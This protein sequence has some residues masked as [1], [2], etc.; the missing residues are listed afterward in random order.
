MKPSHKKILEAFKEKSGINIT[1]D[2]GLNKD[3]K[4]VHFP[5]K[6]EAANKLLS[7]MQVK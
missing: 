4:I 3:A 6:L 7:R 2:K 5:K 1:I